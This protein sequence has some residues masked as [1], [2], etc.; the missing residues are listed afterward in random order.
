MSEVVTI[1][2]ARCALKEYPFPKMDHGGVNPEQAS[3]L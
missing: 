3:Q 2:N 1:K